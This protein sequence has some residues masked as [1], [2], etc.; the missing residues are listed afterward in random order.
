MAAT[1]TNK[2]AFA[3]D[4]DKIK[5]MFTT[6]KMPVV[7]TDAMMAAQKKNVDALI[8]ANKVVTAGYQDLYKRQVALFEAA[9]SQAKD[10]MTDVK[11][12]PM[13]ADQ[14]TQSIDVI[15]SAFEKTAADLNE[16]AEMAQKANT[17]AFE[18]VKA[19][20]EEA[21]TEFKTAAEK[22]VA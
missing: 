10:M 11:A 18:V 8:E 14:A 4:A 6:A 12:Q 3:F 15:K 13:N 5:D 7:D 17:S 2:N 1:K 20:A 16:L 21:V 22:M 9:V 19:R